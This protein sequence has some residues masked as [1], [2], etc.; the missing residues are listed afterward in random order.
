[1]N[2]ERSS[3][4]VRSDA[5]TTRS[6]RI[7]LQQATTDWIGIEAPANTPRHAE[8]QAARLDTRPA[9]RAIAAIDTAQAEAIGPW[10]FVA[11]TVLQTA[12]PNRLTLAFTRDKSPL[13]ERPDVDAILSD[14]LTVGVNLATVVRVRAVPR[15]ED[16]RRGRTEADRPAILRSGAAAKLQLEDVSE[17]PDRLW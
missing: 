7:A 8:R 4:T 12:R 10:E 3:A 14:R 15:T 13:V 1:V 16:F 6:L 9:V 11:A 17:N 5:V 2:D